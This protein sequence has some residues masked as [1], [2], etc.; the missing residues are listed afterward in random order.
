MIV[1]RKLG[2]LALL[3]TA[4]AWAQSPNANFTRA[5]TNA[6]AMR[7]DTALSSLLTADA[8]ST[9]EDLILGRELEF[10]GPLVRPLKA[11][12]VWSAPWRLLKSLNPFAPT[13]PPVNVNTP[14]GDSPLAWATVVGWHPGASAFADP[15][16]HEPKLVLLSITRRQTP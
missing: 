1:L 14:T 11:K 12:S 8:R 9:R 10:S 16:T 2:L 5:T 15:M 6:A 7:Y 13:E 3:A 4:P